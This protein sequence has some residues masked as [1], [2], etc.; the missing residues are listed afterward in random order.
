MAARRTP[1]ESEQLGEALYA[2]AYRLRPLTIRSLFYRAVSSGVIAKTEQEYKTVCRI[3]GKMR[4]RGQMPFEW[5]VD[6]G[7]FVRRPAVWDNPKDALESARDGYRRNLWENQ[8]VHVEVWTEKDAIL[9]V[10]EPVTRKCGR[11]LCTRAAAMPH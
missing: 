2:I 7:R 3:T 11:C 1:L 9:G 8:S 4:K 6:A 10:I 5:L